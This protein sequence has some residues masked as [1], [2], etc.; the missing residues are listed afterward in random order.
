[1][2]KINL[3]G[4]KDVESSYEELKP[5]QEQWLADNYDKSEKKEVNG[6]SFKMGAIKGFDGMKEK[7]EKENVTSLST[8]EI[9]KRLGNFEEKYEEH[10]SGEF[11]I[12][13]GI[14]VMD[15]GIMDWLLGEAIV[16]EGGRYKIRP[17]RWEKFSDKIAMLEELNYRREVAEE[18]DE[19]Y[20][21]QVAK[22]G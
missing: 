19:E 22:Q 15:T 16:E 14:G 6:H 2:P 10:K 7:D 5:I 20:L 11:E 18:K 17:E 4:Q 21:E 13:N 3:R 1:M 12:Y 8:E 9:K